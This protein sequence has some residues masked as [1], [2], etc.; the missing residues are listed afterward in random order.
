MTLG[1]DGRQFISVL[2]LEDEA[3]HQDL[4]Q[5]VPST[6]P[7]SPTSAQLHLL[8]TSVIR[9]GAA[10]DPQP[11]VTIQE[12]PDWTSHKD[13]P[14]ESPSLGDIEPNGYQ[15]GVIQQETV[16]RY[17]SE[18]FRAIKTQSV[19]PQRASSTPP[20]VWFSSRMLELDA[21]LAALQDIADNLEM[22]F[23]KSRML[24]NT[25]EKLTPASA[26]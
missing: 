14:E 16:E 12:D 15:Q 6:R 1:P 2:D 8:A 4:V 10:A 25:I 18:I 24:V 19:G 3:L 26:P 20:T 21:Q 22:D 5:N 9:S 11:A 13:I 7:A 17:D 23:S